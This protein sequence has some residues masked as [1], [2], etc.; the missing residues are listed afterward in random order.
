MRALVQR[1]SNASVAI[2]G[3]VHS[4]IDQGLLVFL[5]VANGDDTEDASYLARRCSQLRIFEDL[6]GK[7][8]LSLK[9]TGG[10]VLAVSQFTLCA[11][12]TKGNRPSFHDVASQE[13]AEALYNQFTETLRLELGEDRVATGVFRAMMQVHLVNNG[14]VT[15]LLESK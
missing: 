3:A 1:V 13:T 2:G 6:E 15:I 9:E 11:D 5:G 8:N 7:L 4:S 14:P 12:T 10:R